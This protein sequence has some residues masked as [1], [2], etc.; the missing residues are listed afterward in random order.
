M[1]TLVVSPTQATIYVMNTN[2]ISSATHVYP[3]V[4]QAFGTNDTTL[5][6]DDSLDAGAGTRAFSGSL[7][8][9]AIFN[10][11][12]S[13][14]QVE[15][16]FY[17]A[18]GVTNYAPTI[19]VEPAAATVYVGQSYQMTASAT[20]SG[21][22]TYH[23]ASAPVGSG[24]P[25][26]QL[27]DGNGLSG[28]GTQILTFQS[29]TLAEQADYVLE[30]QNSVGSVTSAPATLTVQATSAPIF[31]IT[32]SQQEASG[33]DWNTVPNWSDNLA[34]SVSAV[35]EPGS[36]YEVLAGARL[37]TPANVTD[38]TFPG[39]ALLLDGQ[40]VWINNPGAGTTQGELRFKQTNPTIGVG[41][42]TFPLL[43]MNG[44]Q[45]DLGND[46]VC[47]VGGVIEC[48]SNSIF[49]SD[50][51]DDRGYI[52]NA[53]LTGS[54]SIQYFGDS[55]AYP[56]GYTNNL[57]I[58][59]TNNTF[60]GTWDIV[61]GMLLGSASNGLGTNNI[62]IGASGVFETL[63]NVNNSNS[64]LTLQGQMLLTQT[65]T[66]NSVFLGS[67]PLPTGTYTAAYLASNYPAYFPSNWIAK[68]D[69]ATPTSATGSITVIHTPGPSFLQQPQSLTLYPAATAVFSVL[70]G[71][72]PPL[73]YRWYSNNVALADVGNISGSGTPTLTI[74]DVVAGDAA[75][76]TVFV[77]NALASATSQ[78]ATLTLLPTQ[79]AIIPITMQVAEPSGDDWNTPG[80]WT[81]GQGGLPAS[82]SALEFPGS[83][84]EVT[85]TGMLRTP[86][87]TGITYT[88]FLGIQLTVDGQG[89]F[90]PG[91]GANGVEGEIRFK[92]GQGNET[93]YFPLLILAGGQL[94]NGASPSALAE[95]SGEIDVTSNSFIYVDSGGGQ[96]RPWQIDAYLTGAGG[97]FLHDFDATLSGGVNVTGSANTYTGTWDVDQ[98]PLLGSGLNS[99][100]TGSIEVN[101]NGVLETL[102][103]I[104]DPNS[105]LS[106]SNGIMY[107]HQND[108]FQSV[109]ID[110]TPLAV[111][112]WTFAQL[113]SAYPTNFPASWT[114]IFNSPF[115]TASGS[116]TVVGNSVTLGFGYSAHSL[117]LSWSSGSLLQA[118]NL[119]GPWVTNTTAT[120]P[121]VVSPTN[122]QEFFKVQLP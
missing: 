60:N 40:G 71:G 20:G 34:A 28:T 37:R 17:T 44:G 31:N 118:T 101:T 39:D 21:T 49:Y 109:T 64:L 63:Y 122:S 105:S 78:I 15:N 33:A 66:F 95:I 4:V 30:A 108:V 120:S 86:T 42:V 7:D 92:Q 18:S 41:A 52:I 73:V 117:T 72:T 58:A 74:S 26:V 91:G 76:Y 1:V 67:V 23:W 6:G 107:L 102:Y 84:Y 3:H 19:A 65:D 90:A 119:A 96:G 88:N 12:L 112:T 8:E 87:E 77:T 57:E 82:V 83:T 50:S 106:I 53:Q 11:D 97:L 46:G 14:G 116:I 69:A 85:A 62:T 27:T 9:V 110:G 80:E 56:P 5:I 54:T 43:V 36:T 115:S 35:S 29:A 111:G 32:M 103:D 121:F 104:H 93:N 10:T 48:L 94:D 99:L 25:Y 51:A 2:G 68:N 16:L 13:Q 38:T 114:P 98:G 22:V 45:L 47:I 75:S 70:A 113:N 59:G 55:G 24:G 89:I 61:A 100:G 81:D 79:P